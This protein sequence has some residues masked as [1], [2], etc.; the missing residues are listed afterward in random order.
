MNHCRFPVWIE[1]V[2]INNATLLNMILFIHTFL[3]V[4][5]S[6]MG[7]NLASQNSALLFLLPEKS[8]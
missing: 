8:D 6:E 1:I 5:E 2:F 4:V 7:N 3:K